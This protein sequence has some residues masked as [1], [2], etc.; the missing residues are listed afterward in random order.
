MR[1]VKSLAFLVLMAFATTTF[2]V[3]VTGCE[4]GKDEKKDDKKKD[5]K[6]KDD[7]KKD[8]KKEE[9]KA[10]EA[11][12]DEAKAD[13]AAPADGVA[14][15]DEAAPADGAAVVPADGAAVAAADAPA[16]NWGENCTAYFADV[17]TACATPT[18]M[19]K[20]TC[21]AWVQS[22]DMMKKTGAADAAAATAMEPAC[23]QGAEAAKMVISTWK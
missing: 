10:D 12:A 17:K 4:Q 8:D 15:A 16:G 6:K 18:D 5:D 13:E 3:A 7:K 14:K 1:F 21:D 23:K 22:I 20:P 11:K 19:Q 9:A 2:A